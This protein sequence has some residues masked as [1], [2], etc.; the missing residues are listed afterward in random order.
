[1]S[2]L[3]EVRESGYE[4]SLISGDEIVIDFPP[5][6]E[7]TQELVDRLGQLKPILVQDLKDERLSKRD[8]YRYQ[9]YSTR[10]DKHSKGRLVIEFSSVDTGELIQAYINVNITYQRGP[11]K[12]DYFK[13][14]RNGRFWVFPG[15]K[16]ATFWIQAIGQ[17]DKLSTLY[18]QM[19]HL[20][21]LYFS[22]EIKSS[23]SYQQLSNIKR[24]C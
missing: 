1:M 8:I 5:G 16:F 3:D 6:Q 2:K 23:T 19:S 18:R 11:K 12:G 9:G 7:R 17:P 15:S 10:K 14:G 13:T 22:G 24:V 21:P 20:K 4:L